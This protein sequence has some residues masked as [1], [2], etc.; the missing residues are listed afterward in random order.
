MS[1]DDYMELLNLLTKIKGKFLLK[2]QYLPFIEKWARENG[3][4]Y[5]TLSYKLRSQMV[6]G[7]EREKGKILFIANYSLKF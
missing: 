4:D 3:Y 5:I 2:Q 7:S 6:R 1:E